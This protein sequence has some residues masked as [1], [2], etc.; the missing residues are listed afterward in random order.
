[1]KVLDHLDR[2]KDDRRQC[3]SPSSSQQDAQTASSMST[4]GSS[5]QTEIMSPTREHM[6][7]T[8]DKVS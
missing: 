8:S 4:S 6:S 1:M 2:S 7:L 3:G 5:E